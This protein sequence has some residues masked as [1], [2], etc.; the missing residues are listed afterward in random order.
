MFEIHAA[1]EKFAI[2]HISMHTIITK[3]QISSDRAAYTKNKRCCSSNVFFSGEIKHIAQIYRM[4]NINL[5][6]V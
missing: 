1:I 5:F 6:C 2:H 3:C 4:N